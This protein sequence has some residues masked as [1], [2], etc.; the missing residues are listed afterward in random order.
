M[1]ITIIG[2]GMAG[3]LAANMLRRHKVV[4]CEK[5]KAL[6]NNHHAVLRFRTPEV[7]N[8]LGIQFKKVNMI[9]TVVPY[10]NIVAD[11]LS[12]SYKVTGKYRSDRS[13]TDGTV[14]AE[15][16]IAPK[17][18]IKQM[19]K[20]LEIHFDCNFIFKNRNYPIISTIPMPILM[21]HLDYPKKPIFERF[22]GIVG[23]AN[24]QNCDAYVS[25]LFP[26]PM[27]YSR[28]TITGN[29]LI[30][31]FPKLLQSPDK[32]I[33]TEICGHLG[34]FDETFFH[35]E[36]KQQEYFKITEIDEIERKNFIRWATVNHN[37]YSLGRYATWR[38]KLLLDD[39]VHDIRTIEMS[40]TGGEKNV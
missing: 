23:T 6:P 32:I 27:K 29:Q 31:E 14:I 11:S 3:L 35:L 21:H 33:L 5:Q 28:A 38:P 2:A 30:V 17:D 19:S 40:I 24:I 10:K 37:I 8:V 36:F 26:G 15:R 16:Y 18:L 39:L 9:K 25:I 4:I 20:D 12:Y 34:I 22:P 7:G 1:Q 13:I